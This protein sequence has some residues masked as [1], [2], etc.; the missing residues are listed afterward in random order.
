MKIE[1][2]LMAAVNPGGQG[3]TFGNESFLA[4]LD[5][6]RSSQSGDEY[7]S[8]HQAQ[9][10]QSALQFRSS[11][12]QNV[13]APR[14]VEEVFSEGDPV[15][16]EEQQT[17]DNQV[18]SANS[19]KNPVLMNNPPLSTPDVSELISQLKTAG[20]QNF[21]I[22]DVQIRIQNDKPKPAEFVSRQATSGNEAVHKSH[23][24]FLTD[25]HAELSLNTQDLAKNEVQD[26]KKTIKEWLKG[27]GFS[28]SRLIING[29]R[30]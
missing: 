27:K 26:L 16:S 5:P 2:G 29:V 10:Q 23:H 7:Y 4:L 18:L 3:K 6:S 1:A 28:L 19:G 13:S 15:K 25:K 20:K 11:P 17:L 21:V 14:P 24:L 8:Q 30:Q 9:L 22:E 12:D